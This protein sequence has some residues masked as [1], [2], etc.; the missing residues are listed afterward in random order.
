MTLLLCFSVSS[1]DSFLRCC[2][3][4]SARD[5]P[6]MLQHQ[7]HQEEEQRQRERKRGRHLSSVLPP[8]LTT[9]THLQA[10]TCPR[11]RGSSSGS[12][13]PD[14]A[15]RRERRRRRGGGGAEA[16]EKV[17]GREGKVRG[18]AGRRWLSRSEGRK[19]AADDTRCTLRPVTGLS[20]CVSSSSSS[21]EKSCVILMM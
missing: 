21:S 6:R 3:L 11:R 7:E 18:G 16:D 2:S 12:R 8:S 15:G 10:A 4:Q 14:D 9:G 19:A 17:R 5:A 20:P 13:S 1:S